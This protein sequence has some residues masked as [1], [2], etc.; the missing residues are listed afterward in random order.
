MYIIVGLFALGI[1]K[2][3]WSLIKNHYDIILLFIFLYGFALLIQ[4]LFTLVSLDISLWII[5]A[6]LVVILLLIGYLYSNARSAYNVLDEYFDIN[7]MAG[8]EQLHQAVENGK[9]INNDI[10]VEDAIVTLMDEGKIE[11]VIPNRLWRSLKKKPG[12][13]TN[14]I[15]NKEI[16]I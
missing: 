11:E 16:S 9:V 15:E 5:V 8:I 7:E 10:T 12:E 14:S 3:L 2:W 13:F 4:Y 6:V 1:L